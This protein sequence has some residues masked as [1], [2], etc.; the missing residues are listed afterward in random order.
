MYHTA[1][2]L[3]QTRTPVMS[4]PHCSYLMEGSCVV[5]PDGD[6][7]PACED[8]VGGRLPPRPWYRHELVIA[9]TTATIVSI[10]SAILV[11]QVKARTELLK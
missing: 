9:V 10:A 1:P 4:C 3:G 6:P 8:C 7:H 11:Q 2:A 5:C